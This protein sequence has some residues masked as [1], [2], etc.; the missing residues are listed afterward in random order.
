[1]KEKGTHIPDGIKGNERQYFSLW[2]KEYQRNNSI[3]N[4]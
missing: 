1:M 2:D 3:R 4:I